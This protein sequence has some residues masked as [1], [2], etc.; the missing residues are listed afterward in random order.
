MEL[1]AEI[2]AFPF[3][4][5][6]GAEGHCHLRIYMGMGQAVVVAS[7]RQDNETGVWVCTGYDDIAMK[8][9]VAY[10]LPVESTLWIDHGAAVPEFRHLLGE[11]FYMIPLEWL[12]NVQ[13]YR[14][15][16]EREPIS[17]DDL[18]HLLSQRF[19]KLPFE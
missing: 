19:A 5:D 3:K 9:M 1:R 4:D 18:E 13:R 15:P 2:P 16:G 6:M 10:G 8:V 11:T 17:R 12:P 14:L 7:Q